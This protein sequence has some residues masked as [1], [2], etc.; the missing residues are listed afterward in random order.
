MAEAADLE[1]K[2]YNTYQYN[3]QSVNDYVDKYLSVVD[4]VRIVRC[5][6]G[7]AALT[8]LVY[9][10]SVGCENV[11]ALD[12]AKIEIAVQRYLAALLFRGLKK[13]M[14]AQLKYNVH[15]SYVMGQD[16]IL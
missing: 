4:Y 6:P 5:L 10:K 2:L 16:L 9:V 12:T 8:Y 11:K 3:N 15:S 7:N 13:Y 1:A 14:F